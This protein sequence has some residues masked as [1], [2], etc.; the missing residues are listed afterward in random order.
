MELKRKVLHCP[1]CGAQH[2]EKG[3]WARFGHRRH[4]CYSCGE[5]FEDVEPSVGVQ[6]V[7]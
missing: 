4:L 2:V 6:S 3:K 7:E 5:F 1:K